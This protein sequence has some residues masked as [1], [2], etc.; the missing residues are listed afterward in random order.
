MIVSS[1]WAELE[2][3]SCTTECLYLQFC[4]KMLQCSL[5]RPYFKI[6]TLLKKKISTSMRKINTVNLKSIPQ[7]NNNKKQNPKTRSAQLDLNKTHTS[8][9]FLSIFYSSICCPVR[10]PPLSPVFWFSSH[11]FLPF[12]VIGNLNKKAL[13]CRIRSA[14]LS[15]PLSVSSVKE[16]EGDSLI[17]QTVSKGCP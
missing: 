9:A 3:V 17:R 4:K 11:L 5:L 6:C 15:P 13:N 7:K 2:S 12:C 1:W 10:S 8:V 16:R 14:C